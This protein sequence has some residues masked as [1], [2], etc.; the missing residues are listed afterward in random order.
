MPV[1]VRAGALVL[2]GLALAACGSVR[3]PRPPLDTPASEL[4]APGAH[5]TAG[6]AVVRSALVNASIAE[7]G[8]YDDHTQAYTPLLAKLA[9]EG[10]SADDAA[11]VRVAYANA[12]TYCLQGTGD[13]TST[14]WYYTS[15]GDHPGLTT[16]PC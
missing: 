2:A 1:P 7:M 6:D 8:Y 13:G 12:T 14:T 10:L 9:A 16:T 5:L 15:S 3:V 4:A 11:H